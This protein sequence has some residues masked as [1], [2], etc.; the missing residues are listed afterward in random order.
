LRK[1]DVYIAKNYLNAQELSGLNRIVTMYLYYAEMQ[2]KMR[3]VLYMKDWMAKLDAFLQFNE[4]EI[5][6][7]AGK[8]SMTVAKT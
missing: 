1:S 7:D 4:Q 3:K 2:S 5:L 8:I 6:H